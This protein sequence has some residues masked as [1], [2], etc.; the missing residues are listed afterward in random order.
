MNE[1]EG[2][3]KMFQDNRLR[4]K[5]FGRLA[6]MDSKTVKERFPVEFDARERDG[7]YWFRFPG[8]ENYPDVEM[9][10]QSFL[11]YLSAD[12]AGRSVLVVT[13]QVPYK[14][15]RAVLYHLDENQVLTMENVHNCGVQVRGGPCTLYSA[16]KTDLFC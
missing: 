12:F 4:E 7:K 13:H 14:M 10:I 2:D 1:F 15:F 8:G 3:V 16:F 9:R 11:E 5:E 6:G